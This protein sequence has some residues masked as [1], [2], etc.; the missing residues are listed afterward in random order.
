ME[1][2]IV[3]PIVILVMSKFFKKKPQTNMYKIF[4]NIKTHRSCWTAKI[5]VEYYVGETFY[6]IWIDLLSYSTDYFKIES[7]LNDDYPTNSTVV[8]WYD[9]TEPY[10]VSVEK[11][12]EIG[13]LVSSII[14]LSIGSLMLFGVAV[15]LSISHWRGTKWAVYLGEHHHHHHHHHHHYQPNDQPK[16]TVNIKMTERTSLT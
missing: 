8:C 6:T 4:T 1:L 10:L 7:L 9:K 3:I 2:L 11:L 5:N 13:F 12:D 16:Q 14:M 15:F